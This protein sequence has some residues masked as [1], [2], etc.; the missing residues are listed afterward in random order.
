MGVTAI[1]AFWFAMFVVS[2]DA[3]WLFLGVSLMF[4]AA[5]ILRKSLLV[6]LLPLV[7]SANLVLLMNFHIAWD[8]SSAPILIG[9]IVV[10]IAAVSEFTIRRT[11]FEFR[12]RITRKGVIFSTIRNG[13]VSGIFVAFQFGVP[14]L[15]SCLATWF[16]A[17]PVPFS[18]LVHMSIV[19]PLIACTILGTALGGIL[20]FVCD[21]LIAL[22]FENRQTPIRTVDPETLG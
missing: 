4:C 6:F 14:V 20:G 2:P 8:A 18:N 1:I 10:F 7:F 21:G 22:D 11:R 9:F 13:A 3:G 19:F 15:F 5:L 16:T 12:T 17:F